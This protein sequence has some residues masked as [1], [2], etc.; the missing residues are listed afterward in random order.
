MEEKDPEHFPPLP[1]LIV[2][3]EGNL[4]VLSGMW[5]E[6][7]C[8]RM[9]ASF[10]NEDCLLVLYETLTIQSSLLAASINAHSKLAGNLVLLFLLCVAGWLWTDSLLPAEG[11]MNR[12]IDVGFVGEGGCLPSFPLFPLPVKDLLLFIT[13]PVR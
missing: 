1:P 8:F 13:P 2:W 10:F 9:Q 3:G 5:H 6:L 7:C 12:R 4:Y 11:L